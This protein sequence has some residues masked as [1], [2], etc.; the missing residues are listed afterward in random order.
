LSETQEPE[1]S[2][3]L[4]NIKTQD[5]IQQLNELVGASFEYDQENVR[6][7]IWALSQSQQLED[8]LLQLVHEIRREN[9]EM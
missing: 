4:D 8:D 6:P 3:P 2:Q 7:F 5:I 9:P 1:W